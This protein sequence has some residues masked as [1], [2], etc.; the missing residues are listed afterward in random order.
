MGPT[1]VLDV[2][3][4]REI[5][6]LRRKSNPDHPAGSPA[7]YRLSYPGPTYLISPVRRDSGR[8]GLIETQ[9][10]FYMQYH[11][12]VF[13][14]GRVLLLCPSSPQVLGVESM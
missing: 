5:F 11:E 14:G 7:L 2:V 9:K 1:A 8:Y 4:K 12:V 10:A 6:C 3:E 13:V